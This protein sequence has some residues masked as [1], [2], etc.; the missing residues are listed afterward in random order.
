MAL[1]IHLGVIILVGAMLI[2]GLP[3]VVW[4][5][6]YLGLVLATTFIGDHSILMKIVYWALLVPIVAF[7]IPALRRMF[8]TGKAFKVYKS[9]MPPMSSTERE[10]L[11]A[12]SVW[13]DGELFSGSPD[14]NKL[15]DYKEGELT[16]EERAFICDKEGPL[17]VLCSMIDDWEVTAELQDLP[18]EVWDFIKEKG[19]MGMIIPKDYGGLGFSAF[20]HSTVV[21]K[22][23]SRSSTAAVTVMVPNSLGPAELLLNYGTGEQKEY[24]LPRLATGEEV[25]CFALTSPEAGSDAANMP[26]S[27]V[28]TIQDFDGKEGVLGICL[29]WEKRYITLG[30]KATV[31]GLAFKLYDPDHLLGD[32]EELGITLALIPTD[33]PGIEIGERHFPLNSGFQV[34]PNFGRD[35]FIP[36]EWIIGGPDRAG[37]GWPMLMDC[38]AEGRSISLPALSAGS[39]KF[40]A[41]LV[42]AYSRIRRQFGMAIGRFEGVEEAL[43]RIGGY[44]YMVD[45]ARMMTAGGVDS[46]EKPSVISAIVKYHLTEMARTSINDGMDILGGAAVCMGPRNLLARSYQAIPISITVE[47]A[48]ILTR[49]LIIFGQGAIRSHPYLFKEME[50]ARD[51]DAKRGEGAFDKAICSH[52]GFTITNFFRTVIYGLTGSLVAP[53]RGSM[54][55]KRY[56]QHFT[57][58]SA[59]FAFVS[60]VTLLLLGGALKRKERLSA[61]LGD[62]LSNLYLASAVIKRFEG[63]GAMRDEEPLL[64]WCLEKNLYDAQEAMISLFDNYPVKALGRVLR[65]LVFPYGRPFKGPGDDLGHSIAKILTSPSPLRDRVTDGIFIPGFCEEGGRISVRESCETVIE[66]EKLNLLE[67]ALLKVAAAEEAE[68]RIKDGVREGAI[69][70]GTFKDMIAEGIREGYITEEEGAFIFEAGELRREVIKVDSFPGDLWRFNRGGEGRPDDLEP[71]L[72]PDLET[73]EGEPG[74]EVKGAEGG[75]GDDE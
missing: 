34:G 69:K 4:T 15:F 62:V 51:S 63:D 37:D 50:A 68:G 26:D 52:V 75:T 59:A 42:G 1:L 60:D 23:A 67:V 35:V 3:L 10:A 14:W 72:K 54:D 48:N 66:G 43:G 61:R 44:A 73:K 6:I 7:N 58:L 16:E 57:R 46:G 27:G 17:E 5:L 49:S 24:Y 33:T 38:L 30:P 13:W 41:R 56:V 55:V 21:Q 65:F 64:Q 9:I 18:P 36:L 25:P 20:A 74:L 12:G 29:N 71:D 8:V 32:R 2:R 31:L 19:F 39:T 28:V 11:E 40:T 22:L 53:P 45:S 47:G 70:K